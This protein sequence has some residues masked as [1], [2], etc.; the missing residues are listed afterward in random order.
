MKL[1]FMRIFL[2]LSYTLIIAGK[3]TYVSL[4]EIYSLL[5]SEYVFPGEI[6]YASKKSDDIVRVRIIFNYRNKSWIARL[7]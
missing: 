2:L 1:P 3:S 5:P 6:N 4:I 7:T